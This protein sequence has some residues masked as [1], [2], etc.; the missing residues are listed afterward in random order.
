MPNRQNRHAVDE[1]HDLRAERRRLDSREADDADLIGEEYVAQIIDIVQ[2]NLDR[3]LLIRRFGQSAINECRRRIAVTVIQLEPKDDERGRQ[4]DERN[5]CY[6]K[7]NYHCK[8]NEDDDR[9]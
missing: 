9:G 4:D 6:R 7:Y 3:R 2:N 8:H 1:L 5:G